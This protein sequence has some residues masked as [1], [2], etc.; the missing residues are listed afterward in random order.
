MVLGALVKIVFVVLSIFLSVVMMHNVSQRLGNVMLWSKEKAGLSL[1]E[2]P[3]SS[4]ENISAQQKALP[5]GVQSLWQICIQAQIEEFTP[6]T[7]EKELPRFADREIHDRIPVV[8]SS[9]LSIIMFPNLETQIDKM[10]AQ[11]QLDFIYCAKEGRESVREEYFR[12]LNKMMVSKS[13]REE[14]RGFQYA[15]MQKSLFSKWDGIQPSLVLLLKG[16]SSSRK[17]AIDQLMISLETEAHLIPI[18]ALEARRLNAVE[19]KEKLRSIQRLDPLGQA[20]VTFALQG[21]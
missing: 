2:N 7:I 13:P 17:E 12:V 16:C 18:I 19:V 6:Q 15:C 1:I 9:L 20:M 8:A 4:L 10:C 14:L 3:C 21:K 11:G 5:P